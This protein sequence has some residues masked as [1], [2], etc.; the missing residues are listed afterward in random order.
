MEEIKAEYY[1]N[2]E[3]SWLAFNERV[4][5][6]A[7]DESNPLYERARFLAITQSNMDEWFQ[8][9]V[10]SLYQM[11][12]VTDKADVT[13][14]TPEE[15]LKAVLTLAE[16]QVKAQ[17]K[18]LNKEI[19]PALN[20]DG[21][22][23]LSAKELTNQ[24]KSE[25]APYFH[26]SVF[27]ILTPMADD[28]TR[29]F[30]FLASES[31][32]LVVRLERSGQERLA[33]VQVPAILPR[34][35][36][37]PESAG[38]FILLEELIKAFIDELFLGHTVKGVSSFHILRDMELD[39]ADD[40]APNM[41]AEVQQ[42]LFER[43][44]GMVIRLVHEQGMTKRV[45]ERL[46]VALGISQNRLYR[47]DGPVDLSFL[48]EMVKFGKDKDARFEPFEEYLD[49]RLSD[50]RI[51]EAIAEGDILLHHP[52]DSFQPVVNLIQ[53]AALDQNVL[54]IKMTLYR[55]SGNSP[56]IKALGAAARAGKQVTALVEVKARFDEENNVHWAKELEEQGVHVTYGLKGLKVHAK[57]TLIVRSEGDDIKRYVHLATGN[58]NDTTAHFYTDLGLLTTNAEL[59]R[60][61]ASVF[62][63]LTGYSDPDY[64]N[65][66]YM[67]PDGI[68]DALIERLEL[69]RKAVKKGHQVK[70]RFKANSL[71]DKAMID[72]IFKASADG[73]NVEMIIRGITMMKPNVP[74]ISERVEIHSIVGRFLEH[75]R[76]YIFEIDGKQEVFL[77]SA[78]LMSRNLSRR[79]ELMFPIL[80]E[81]LAKRVVEIFDQLW[82]DN[83]KTRVLQSNDGWLKINRRNT[84]TVNAQERFIDESRTKIM[85]QREQQKLTNAKSAF[86]PVK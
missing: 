79:V 52:F 18:L 59:G 37:I 28:Q 70:V 29:P 63:V 82:A 34:V 60:D 23:V 78:D 3:I 64:F 17:Y 9:R 46:A 75:S 86:E 85:R 44:R 5:E 35:V 40:D 27:P 13:G 39:V 55:V 48:S 51:F 47:V 16:Q 67:S 66:L 69:A 15:Q 21:L 11:R 12:H 33:I 81:A 83:V 61:V 14:L 57:A 43:E 45:V 62:N 72:E 24:Q 19:L 80:D 50:Q 77:S 73:V 68:R 71:S 20:K 76:I 8:V 41:L 22:T 49:E 56:I 84:E 42:R 26:T 6:E 58:Y 65:A 4:L 25:L 31:I 7:R 38:Q 30:P 53:Q 32:N 2:R 1:T 36:A 54:A 10:A 74:K